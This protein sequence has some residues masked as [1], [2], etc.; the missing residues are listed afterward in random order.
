MSNIKLWITAYE[1]HRYDG[2]YGEDLGLLRGFQCA[3][4]TC[5]AL[6]QL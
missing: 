1:Y 2:E 3:L 5:R 4:S 6:S